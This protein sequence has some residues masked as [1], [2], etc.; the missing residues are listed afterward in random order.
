[1]ERKGEVKSNQHSKEPVMPVHDWQKVSAGVYHDFH[2]AWLA[3]LRK[4][5][6]RGILPDG[7]YAL[8]DQIAG[9]TGP[10]VL[11]L[12]GPTATERPD[13]HAAVAS[14]AVSPP[15]VRH[16]VRMEK[17][18]YARKRKTLAIR[19]SSDDRIVAMIEIVSPGNKSSTLA[20]RQ[21]LDKVA[22][23]LDQGI[24]LL[25]VDLFR[26]TP[27]DPQGIHGA[28]LAEWENEE[29]APPPDKPLTV[30]SYSADDVTTA[31]V[32]HISAGDVLPE[33]P[34]FLEPELYV[35]VPLEATY[36]EAW[37]GESHR[38]QQVLDA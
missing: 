27:R 17:A 3:E 14:V 9:K 34:L 37:S 19:H 28:I 2:N 35:H 32:E 15:K 16:V 7:F 11:S 4:A 20:F 30:A 22:S 33:M 23:A 21:F 6:N 12:Q 24:H 38:W 18:A 8:I 26:P 36:L 25:V 5:L 31:Y 10:D 1:V 29:Y 13:R